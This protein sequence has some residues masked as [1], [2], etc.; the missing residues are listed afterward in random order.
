MTPKDYSD[1]TSP[2]NTSTAVE[3]LGKIPGRRTSKQRPNPCDDPSNREFH[4]EMG[5]ADNYA[6]GKVRL[7]SLGRSCRRF[8]Y[9][10]LL[11]LC[12]QEPCFLGTSNTQ[13]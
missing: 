6:Q 12:T 1:N 3:T 7:A 2:R 4:L 5:Q 9:A 10:E 8:W 13:A 11:P